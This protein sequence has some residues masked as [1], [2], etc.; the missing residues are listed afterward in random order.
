[1]LTHMGLKCKQNWVVW[2]EQKLLSIDSI[3]GLI[4]DA[5]WETSAV[6]KLCCL[7]R[8]VT[9]IAFEDHPYFPLDGILEKNGARK[10]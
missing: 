1:M 9:V 7:Q 10:K 8:N 5:K 3:A 6:T 2:H 4:H